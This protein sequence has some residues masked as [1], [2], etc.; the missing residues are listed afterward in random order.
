MSGW[1]KKIA[2]LII[3]EEKQIKDSTSISIDLYSTF[4][5][6]EVETPY[7][8]LNINDKTV[9][10]SFDSQMDAN[11]VFSSLIKGFNPTENGY[12]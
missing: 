7:I 1:D 11:F 5:G 12:G 8:C 3:E 4:R 6:H 10:F 2:T 9:N